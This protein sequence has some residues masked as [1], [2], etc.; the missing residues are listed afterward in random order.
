MFVAPG[1]EIYKNATTNLRVKNWPL[2]NMK[3]G[4]GRD[5]LWDK[6]ACI[7]AT[8]QSLWPGIAAKRI[9]HPMRKGS[10][11]LALI[12]TYIMEAFEL[13]EMSAGERW[14]LA[15]KDAQHVNSETR[16]SPKKAKSDKECH[17]AL[18]WAEKWDDCRKA[19]IEYK[20]D[21][22]IG[23]LGSDEYHEGRKTNNA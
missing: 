8:G 10:V 18:S 21:T 15:S 23:S 4:P 11:L 6:Y 3:R 1:R 2:E 22:V 20:C 13:N 14:K 7:A 5:D 17:I 19:S 16:M 12:L 9:T